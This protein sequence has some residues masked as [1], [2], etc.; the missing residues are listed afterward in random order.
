MIVCICNAVRERDIRSVAPTCLTPAQA[1]DTL[2]CRAKCGQCVLVARA[3]L[4]DER[5]A[6]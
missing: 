2:G 1:Y 3:I 6:A 4:E 5:R